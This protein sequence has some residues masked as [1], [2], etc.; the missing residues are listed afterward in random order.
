MDIWLHRISHC[1]EVSYKLLEKGYISIG[2]SA[3]SNEE[4][5]NNTIS[6][7]EKF[8]NNKYEEIWGNKKTRFSLWRF[9]NEFKQGDLVLIPQGNQF[10]I[11]KIIDEPKLFKDIELNDIFN[12]VTVKEDG[13]VYIDDEIIDIGFIWKAE[14]L[15][16]D[17]LRRDVFDRALTSR[18]KIRNTNARITDLKENVEK[19]IDL[20]KSNKVYNLY[21]SIL[22]NTT[23]K[24]EEII[25]N[26][27]DDA[28]FEKLIKWYL[29]KIGASDVEIPSKNE[30]GK[31]NGAD[32]DVRATFENLKVI[33]Y[34]Q[35]KYHSGCTS[36]WAIN[37]ITEYKS[38]KENTDDEYTYIPW[39]ISSAKGYSEKAV[40]KAREYGVRLINRKEFAKM[41]ID[42]GFDDINS[43]FLL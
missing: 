12:N 13:K 34:V 35:A 4:F 28:K 36:E 25:N 32:A 17:M 21:E 27:L 31:E 18:M 37:Q 39:V 7:D 15:V 43:A 23:D 2:F 22:D 30:S 33:I 26:K 19:A 1:S 10:S 16:K 29:Y 9:L 42:S 20:Y 14:P 3:V 6:G 11:Y 41:L 38:Q 24:I 5:M 40:N 8:F